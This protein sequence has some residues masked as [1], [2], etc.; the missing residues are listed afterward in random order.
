MRRADA[1]DWN[2]LTLRGKRRAHV[3]KIRRVVD[4]KPRLDRQD[5][6]IEER[7]RIAVSHVPR[8]EQL[9]APIE[10]DAQLPARANHVLAA[11]WMVRVIQ[12][13]DC[14]RAN[15]SQ[16]GAA[17][18]E[19]SRNDGTAHPRVGA[20]GAVASAGDTERRFLVARGCL[21]DQIDGAAEAVPAIE[22]PLRAAK[23]FDPV[24]IQKI[25]EHHGRP[26]QVHAIE[27]HS[28]ARIGPGQH[29]I[30]AYPAD[31]DLSAPG[32]LREGDSGCAPGDVLDR[33]IL[34][35]SQLVSGQDAHGHRDGLH[36]SLAR[37]RRRDDGLLQDQDRE[38]Q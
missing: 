38:R 13:A 29:R 21:R 22:R 28:R 35:P 26:R 9:A 37:P 34:H 4:L 31:G 33:V 1:P 23:H 14:T 7:R 25:R 24:E 10:H 6:R 20:K 17:A 12:I 3:V 15:T 16:D 19:P 36:I 32:V 30:G 18:H 5:L 11:E 27:I 8:D 2:V